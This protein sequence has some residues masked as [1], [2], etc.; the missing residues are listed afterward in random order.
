MSQGKVK[1]FLPQLLSFADLSFQQYCLAGGKSRPFKDTTGY[2]A[3]EKNGL[4]AFSG[5]SRASKQASVVFFMGS[6]TMWGRAFSWQK[7]DVLS[8]G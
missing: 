8:D 1:P 4:S 2:A 5:F 6:W 3:E 7:N